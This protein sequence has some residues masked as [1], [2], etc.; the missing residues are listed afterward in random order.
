MLPKLEIQQSSDLSLVLMQQRLKES[1]RP[2]EENPIL[3]GR[4]IIV[5]IPGAGTHDIP[6]G[7]ARRPVGWIVTD[8]EGAA[9]VAL[10]RHAW[11]EKML[12]LNA[13]AICRVT[14][15]VF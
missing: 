2:L 5:E 6:H 10:S 11:D 14:L 1:L 12:R 9:G 4:M 15:W 8:L 3:D 7:L 13:T